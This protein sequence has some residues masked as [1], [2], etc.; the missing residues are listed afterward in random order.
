MT[1]SRLLEGDLGW[2]WEGEGSHKDAVV[3]RGFIFGLEM[4]SWPARD[5]I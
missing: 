5:F 3:E 1:S 2:R 4:L